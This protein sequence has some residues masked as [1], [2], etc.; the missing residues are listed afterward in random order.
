MLVPRTRLVARPKLGW[1]W[2]G[3]A[4]T[5]RPA[6]APGR[7][8]VGVAAEDSGDLPQAGSRMMP[9]P[10]A[11]MTLRSMADSHSLGTARSWPAGQRRTSDP[12][13]ADSSGRVESLSGSRPEAV[14]RR[15]KI[16]VRD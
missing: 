10:T 15:V 14:R 11:V 9:P 12:I 1:R 16:T 7:G 6:A 4:T 8:V 2:A 13:E 5:V 3:V